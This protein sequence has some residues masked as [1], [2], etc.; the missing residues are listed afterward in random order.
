MPGHGGGGR[1]RRTD[2]M[3]PAAR[4]LA[5]LE[6]AVRRRRAALARLEPVVVHRKAHRTTRLAPFESGIDEHAIQSFAFGLR[7]YET[8][9]GHHHREPHI[10]RDAATARDRGCGAQILDAR[11]RA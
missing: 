1:H 2:E 6:V 9:T 4:A 5:T 8:R 10:F 11:I 3:G 7:L